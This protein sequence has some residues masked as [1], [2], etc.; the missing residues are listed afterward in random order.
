MKLYDTARGTAMVEIS[1]AEPERVLNELAKREIAFWDT[2]PKEDFKISTTIAAKDYATVCDLNGRSGCEIRL[3]ATVG[4]KRITDSIRRR[5]AFILC[6]ALCFSLLAS[7]SYFIW[8]ISVEGNETIS[9][10]EL[11]RAIA[12]AGLEIGDFAPSIDT[13]AIKTKLLL[14][15]GNIAWAAVNISGSSVR[16]IVHE[17]K[18]K[19][20]MVSEA[21]PQSIYASKSG[22]VTKLSVL[23]GSPTVRVG[24]T[25]TEGELLVS[26]EMLS[27]T[28]EPRYVHSMATVEARTWYEICCVTPLYEYAKTDIGENNTDFSLL[29][30]KNR[31][32]FYSDGRNR[33]ASCDKIYKIRQLCLGT[34]LTLP[35]GIS[36]AESVAR[37]TEYRQID[38]DAA[39]RRMEQ[40]LNDELKARIGDGVIVTANCTVSQGD[41]LLYVTLRAE[42]VENIAVSGEI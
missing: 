25:V 41:E 7:S 6:L 22:V 30:R 36:I 18:A 31:I 4:G 39:V 20:E 17:R 37:E 14:Q 2:S 28:A 1:G 19:P 16:V 27:E 42:C 38:I 10:A 35:F 26:G 13:E 40:R 12:N 32:N 33:A 15:N 29:I 23:D 24:D 9:D 8:N 5:T 34:Y 11:M 3:V 21:S